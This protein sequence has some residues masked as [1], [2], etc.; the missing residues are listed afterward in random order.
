MEKDNTK[1]YPNDGAF[2]H[3]GCDTASEQYGLSKRE[4]FAAIALQG[5]IASNTEE[6]VANELEAL[7]VAH[8]DSLID[9]L[10]DI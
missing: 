3:G 2:A 1:T 10:N 5:L 4:Y 6:S 9:C 7:A 8:A